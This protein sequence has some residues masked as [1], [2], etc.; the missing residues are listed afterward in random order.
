MSKPKPVVVVK[1]KPEGKGLT[2]KQRKEVHK[3]VNQPDEIKFIETASAAV[4]QA[5][6]SMPNAFS[7]DNCLVTQ[8]VTDTARLGD[9]LVAKSL[10]A[11]FT[12]TADVNNVFDVY[13]E[14]WL[15]WHP[16]STTYAIA[17][18]LLT[19]PSGIIDVWSD[20]NHDNRDNFTILVDKLHSSQCN[21]AADSNTFTIL[22]KVPLKYAKKKMQ[23]VAGT[24]GGMNHIMCLII[25]RRV[26]GATGA[27]ITYQSRFYFADA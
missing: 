11:R 23:Y 9:Q 18:V 21:A 8:G 12:I 15:Q 26:S 19:G 1:R 17:S 5:F 25:G 3:M 13:R 22:R 20:Y 10:R 16:N 24:T 4:D 7:L 2:K 6:G 14:I 27:K